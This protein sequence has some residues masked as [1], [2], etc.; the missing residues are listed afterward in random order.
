MLLNKDKAKIT[1][2]DFTAFLCSLRLTL[3]D[4]KVGS[5]LF[6]LRLSESRTVMT[7]RQ[8][9]LSRDQGVDIQHVASASGFRAEVKLVFRCN[10]ARYGAACMDEYARIR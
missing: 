3:K 4:C 6:E 10:T 8:S 1:A 9:L 7:A 5:R 2:I